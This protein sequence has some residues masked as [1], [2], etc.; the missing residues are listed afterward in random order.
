MMSTETDMLC[1]ITCS[2]SPITVKVT[3]V[4][5]LKLGLP[6]IQEEDFFGSNVVENIALVLGI[7]PSQV[8]IVEAVPES[9]RRRRR[10]LKHLRKK[11]NISIVLFI[12]EIG[13]NPPPTA[14][15][16]NNDD[17]IQQPD[18]DSNINIDDIT[19]DIPEVKVGRLNPLRSVKSFAPNKQI[20]INNKKICLQYFLVIL[21][22][23]LHNYLCLQ[24]FLVIL[25]ITEDMFPLF[26]NFSIT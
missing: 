5:L 1:L 26:F 18:E 12:I 3:P 14:T 8:R 20:T 2:T 4:V 21:K 24:Y 6:S 7:S 19:A 25:K 17:I 9:S 13:D 23:R 11:R 15:E 16:P 22:R 10:D